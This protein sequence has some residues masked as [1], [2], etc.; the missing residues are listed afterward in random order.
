MTNTNNDLVQ[1]IAGLMPPAVDE[2][3]M[4]LNYKASYLDLLAEMDQEALIRAVSNA[5]TFEA[6]FG[7][8]NV[9]V[10]DTMKTPD[11]FWELAV[12]FAK[13]APEERKKVLNYMANAIRNLGE[14]PKT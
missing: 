1:A 5:Q 14:A 3:K 13:V 4:W 11:E 6:E 9:G 12:R 8:L 7:K 2:K 10:P